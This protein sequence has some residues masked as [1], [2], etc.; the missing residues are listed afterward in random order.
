LAGNL[1]IFGESGKKD[2]AAGLDPNLKGLPDAT[3]IYLY[4]NGY[5]SKAMKVAPGTY[6]VLVTV[7]YDGNLTTKDKQFAKT[8]KFTG[9][10]GMSK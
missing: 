3:D 2:A 4:W 6:R 10:V 5:N 7:S 9:L 1:V 8:Q